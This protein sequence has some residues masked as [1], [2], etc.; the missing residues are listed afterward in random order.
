MCADRQQ[1]YAELG[2][3]EWGEEDDIMEDEDDIILP[4]VAW[5]EMPHGYTPYCISEREMNDRVD[6]PI[7]RGSRL[8]VMD[9]HEVVRTPALL[10]A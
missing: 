3:E 10:R 9:P 1:E 2:F 6:E 4:S 7:P 8:V 5:P